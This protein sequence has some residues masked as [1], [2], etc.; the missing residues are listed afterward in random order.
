MSTAG[1]NIDTGTAHPA[2]T[3]TPK[4]PGHHAATSANTTRADRP[5]PDPRST[6]PKPPAR[7]TAAT[8]D[9]PGTPNG[10]TPTTRSR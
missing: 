2:G 4:P 6:T 9:D 3:R 5:A 7:H 8:S 1:G 10:D